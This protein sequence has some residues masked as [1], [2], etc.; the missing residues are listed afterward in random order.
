MLYLHFGGRMVRGDPQPCWLWPFEGVAAL[1]LPCASQGCQSSSVRVCQGTGH[2]ANLSG[3]PVC[4]T[5]TLL[6]V[7]GCRV[8][9]MT[10][11]RPGGCT[12]ELPYKQ[13]TPRGG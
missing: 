10:V 12:A 5:R 13:D 4:A 1:C 7:P 8:V 9:S 3:I 2:V 6:L 11:A